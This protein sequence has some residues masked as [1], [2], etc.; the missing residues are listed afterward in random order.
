MLCTVSIMRFR[1]FF[2]YLVSCGDL[3]SRW[4]MEESV[5][6][7]LEGPGRRIASGY[8]EFDRSHRRSSQVRRWITS[9]Y[10]DFDH[11]VEL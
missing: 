8:S 1:F 7:A 11:S 6:V 2:C 9:R 5:V 3:R 4:T 10:P